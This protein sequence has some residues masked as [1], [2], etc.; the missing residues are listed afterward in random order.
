MVPK[1][2]K[3]PVWTKVQAHEF[4]TGCG[5]ENYWCN[6]RKNNKLAATIKMLRNAS[7]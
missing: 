7:Y 2:T 4:Y 3:S 5:K 6:F 1:Q